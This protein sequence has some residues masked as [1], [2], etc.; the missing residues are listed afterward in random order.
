MENT[1]NKVITIYDI[2]KEAGV[3]PS[4]V[5]RVLTN[6]ANVRSDKKEKIQ[7]IIDKY[8]FKPNALARGLSDTKTKII[9]IVT[10]DVR[11]PFY[12]SVFVAVEEVAR[13]AGYTVLLGNSLGDFQREV[14]EVTTLK[15]QQVDAI[16][17]FGGSVDALITNDEYAKFIKPIAATTPLIVS[18][19]LDGVNCYQVRIDAHEASALLTE[20]LIQLGH[21]RIALVGGRMD[22]TSTHEKYDTYRHLIKQH[23]IEYK[24]EYIINGGYDHETG[25]NG[26]KKLLGLKEIPTAVIAINDFCATGILRALS[27][28]GLNAP[29]DISVVSY[30]NTYMAEFSNPKLTSIDYDY[31]TFGKKLIDTA[32][33]TI[34]KEE[35]PTL[36][37]IT[38]H[39]VVRESSGRAKQ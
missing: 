9:G 22:V 37:T 5:S 26:M 15:Q 7:A 21:K 24:A 35:M 33:K 32:I 28:V 36:Q 18:G 31:E 23:G 2:A 38:P 12:A 10:A 1:E 3:S 16:I 30:D 17:Q 19:K 11:N 13:K 20:H 4:T 25:Y 8:N 29:T 34:N 14:E 39:L 27:E 6:N